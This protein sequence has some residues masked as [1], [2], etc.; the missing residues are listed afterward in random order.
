M[1]LSIVQTPE[2]SLAK[3]NKVYVNPSSVFAGKFVKFSKEIIYL[4]E[5][6]DLIGEKCIGLNSIHRLQHQFTLGSQQK[7]TIAS[8]IRELDVVQCLISIPENK[9]LSIDCEELENQLKLLQTGNPLTESQNVHIGYQS[10]PVTI[11]VQTV[12]LIEEK[13]GLM[14]LLS[15]AP[16]TNCGTITPE[17]KF[18]F[19]ASGKNIKLKNKNA[20]V[21]NKLFK[22]DLNL[23]NLG[24]G[25]L[26]QQFNTIFRSAFSSR[27]VPKAI[28]DK[29]KLKHR[30]GVL[31]YGPPGTGKTLIARQIGKLLNCKEPKIVSGP[32]LLDKYVGGSEG[33]VRELFADAEADRDA[34]IDDVLHLIIFDEADAL[35]KKRGSRNDST[36]VADNLVNQILAKIDGVEELNNILI[37][38]MTNRKDVIDDAILRSGRLDIHIEIGLPNESG[39]QDIL[40]IHTINVKDRLAGDVDLSLVAK[41]TKN[42]TGA[43]LQQLV[44]SATSFAITRE[45]DMSNL[46]KTDINP[47][48]TQ[49]DFLNAIDDVPT[50]FGKISDEI[51]LVTQTPFVMWSNDIEMNR[52]LIRLSIETLKHGNNISFLVT[53]K[54]GIGKTKFLSHIIKDLDIACV[55]MISPEILLRTNNVQNHLAEMVDACSRAEISV[56]FL[57]GFERLIK[58]SRY[59][60]KYDNDV[61]QLLMTVLRLSQKPDKK[62][63]IFCTANDRTVLQDLEIYDMFD[64]QYEYPE[65]INFDKVTEC[66]PQTI[67]HLDQTDVESE[68][69]ICKI[70]RIVKHNS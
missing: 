6:H 33:K 37:I 62:M 7:V 26:D 59:G 55:K 61:L 40:N 20:S 50:L 44:T 18:M 41:R 23:T 31:L 46:T 47:I 35:F 52:E 42:Y 39:R 34:G 11:N 25:G 8:K 45:I 70:M 12:T 63:I 10:V 54:T 38:A 56:I 69:E 30:K 24:I 1:E 29:M 5:G 68:I 17:T 28:A 49:Q 48:I 21:G 43:E 3:T 66:F 57:D 14:G 9:F 53:G 36:G 64:S 27:V 15:S 65:V 16:P 13:S 22:K 2:A 4:A 51:G 60:H 19:E 67:E 58:W 32:E